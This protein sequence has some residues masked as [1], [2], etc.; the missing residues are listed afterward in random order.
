LKT[1]ALLTLLIAVEPAAAQTLV[2]GTSAFTATRNGRYFV[3]ELKTPHRVLSTS[4]VTGGESDALRFLVNHQSMEAAG[5]MVRHDTIVRL[6]EE[7]YHA[8][9]AQALR[10]QPAQMAMMGTAA[11]INYLAHVT[12]EFRDIRVDAFVTAGVEGN[13]TRAG[14]PASW[15][16]A[17][18]KTTFVPY[19]GTINTIV[20]INRPLTPGAEARVVMVMS[21]AKAAALAELAV[22]S[23]VTPT[24]ATG[25]GTDQFIVAAPLDD[26]T[27]PLRNSGT[28]TKLGE[29][30]GHA[31]RNAT[32]EALRWQN[33]LERSYTRNITRALGRFG[34]TEEVLLERLQKVLPAATYDLLIKNTLTVIME[35]RVSAAAYAYAAVLDRLQFGTLSSHLSADMLRDQAATAAVGLSSKAARWQEFR[36]QLPAAADD[37]L[38]PFVHGIALGWAARWDD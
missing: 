25:T 32:L 20:M 23:R 31:V 34:L 11:N 18:G 13:A 38:T 27:V 17:D 36:D 26:T 3:V 37:R 28:H 4:A 14:D 19:H 16:E 29:L 24:I 12:S 35:P 6:S 30:V 22:P 33:G 15:Y 2:A 1:L 21:E 10:L 5:D 8:M 7:E 9:V